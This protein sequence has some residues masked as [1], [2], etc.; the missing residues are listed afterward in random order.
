MGR[1]RS[2][3]P[4]WSTRSLLLGLPTGWVPIRG[5]RIGRAR[6]LVGGTW[7]RTS[8]CSGWSAGAGAVVRAPLRLR[9]RSLRRVLAAVLALT[10]PTAS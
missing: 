1:V 3:R 10:L 5:V 4:L 7:R 9:L 6:P 8:G 2:L